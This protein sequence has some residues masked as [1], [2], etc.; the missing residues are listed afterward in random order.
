MI[1]DAKYILFTGAGFTANFGGFLKVSTFIERF[2]KRN[3][4]GIFFTI[5]QDLLPER[6]FGL[7]NP[8]INFKEERRERLGV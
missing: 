6:F 7:S 4:N 8:G 3:K 1:W 5:N 2:T